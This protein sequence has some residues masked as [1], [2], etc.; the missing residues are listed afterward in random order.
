MTAEKTTM[1]W[2]V[3][4]RAVPPPLSPDHG[5][6]V[7][8]PRDPANFTSTCAI[9]FLSCCEVSLLFSNDVHPTLLPTDNCR[10]GKLGSVRSN[11]IRLRKLKSWSGNNGSRLTR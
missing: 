11:S 10:Q 9:I 7:H 2:H 8:I 4:P 6:R 3:E 1:D 5:M